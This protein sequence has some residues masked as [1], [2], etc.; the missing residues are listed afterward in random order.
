MKRY[1]TLQMADHGRIPAAAVVKGRLQDGVTGLRPPV[2]AVRQVGKH[3]VV[4]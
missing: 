4:G 2:R 3:M 1:E